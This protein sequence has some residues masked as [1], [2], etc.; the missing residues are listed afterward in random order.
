M[1]FYDSAHDVADE[2]LHIQ[3]LNACGIG[4]IVA[5]Q[6]LLRRLDA[7]PTS[8]R[9][10]ISNYKLLYVALRAKHY[11]VMQL[12]LPRSNVQQ[13]LVKCVR[14]ND[15]E[16]LLYLMKHGHT[17]TQQLRAYRQLYVDGFI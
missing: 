2:D 11:A 10:S 17:N 1:A 12:L 7:R 5:V 3:L 13:L 8:S 14:C 16:M 4:H 6:Q 15:S 9:L